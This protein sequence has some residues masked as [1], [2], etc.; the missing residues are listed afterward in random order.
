[1]LDMVPTGLVHRATVVHFATA[2][3]KASTYMATTSSGGIRQVAEVF[4]AFSVRGHHDESR[5]LQGDVS[6][7]CHWIDCQ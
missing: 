1:M 4:R 7:R 5:R 3:A 2:N 6:Y